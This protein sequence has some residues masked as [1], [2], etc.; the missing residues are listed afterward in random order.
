MEN[1][2]EQVAQEI[3]KPERGWGMASFAKAAR[4]AV[5]TAVA[6]VTLAVGAAGF[7]T[8]ANAQTTVPYGQQGVTA[9][10]TH[11]QQK[12][13]AHE[14]AYQQRIQ[15]LAQQ[16]EAQ[17]RQAEAQARADRARLQQQRT[18]QLATYNSNI[19]RI[20]NNQRL[21]GSER[22][23]QISAATQ[24]WNAQQ[25]QLNARAVQ[26]DNN[27]ENRRI[28][29]DRAMTSLVTSLDRQ[30]ANQEPYKSILRQQQQQQN[31]AFNNSAPT[32][33]TA[34]SAGGTANMD[35]TYE[36][37]RERLY[38]QYVDAEVKA[39]RLPDTSD[40]FFERLEQQQRQQQQS[41]QQQ[42]RTP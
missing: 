34:A 2:Q 11:Q 17:M 10:V 39:G 13:W 4:K 15:Q 12:P 6:G 22:V 35:K 37:A 20:R 9:T 5:I 30:Y 32:S 23:L 7:A 40:K 36:Q 38:K 24:N 28:N 8:E 27:I 14:V 41:Q 26:I 33:A 25:Q 29:N 19:N 1:K 42:P 21:S 31:A 3:Q 16:Q 18:Q